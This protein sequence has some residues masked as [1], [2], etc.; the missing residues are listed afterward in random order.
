MNPEFCENSSDK[1]RHMPILCFYS[2]CNAIHF[3]LPCMNRNIF[4]KLNAATLKP[5]N[6]FVLSF[7]RTGIWSTPYLFRMMEGTVSTPF[8]ILPM[9]RHTSSSC[10][11]FCDSILSRDATDTYISAVRFFRTGLHSSRCGHCAHFS[12]R[13]D[14]RMRP[15]WLI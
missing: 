8:L 13:K 11:L 1:P 5:K 12:R 7:P 3:V 10:M 6:C 15:G 9:S 4:M 2:G 14:T